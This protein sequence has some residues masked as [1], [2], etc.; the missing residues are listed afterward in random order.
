MKEL[1]FELSR[2]EKSLLSYLKEV[3]NDLTV[4]YDLKGDA[5]LKVEYSFYVHQKKVTYVLTAKPKKLSE[6][7]IAYSINIKADGKEY[8]CCL[9]KEGLRADNQLYFA[10]KNG[11]YKNYFK[12]IGLIPKKR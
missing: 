9:S 12:S 2:M 6:T 8:K 1:G 10:G 4:S 7:R 5:A 3:M 11:I